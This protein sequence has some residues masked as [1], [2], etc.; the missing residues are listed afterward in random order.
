LSKRST[1]VLSF[2][3]R[4]AI[5]ICKVSNITARC[6]V[7]IYPFTNRVKNN[8]QPRA[9]YYV[10]VGTV[11]AVAPQEMLH[12]GICEAYDKGLTHMLIQRDVVLVNESVAPASMEAWPALARTAAKT[13]LVNPQLKEELFGPFSLLVECDDKAELLAGVKSLHGQLPR[14]LSVLL[15]TSGME[16]RY[17]SA[18]YPDRPCYF[19][20]P[21]HRRGGVCCHSTWRTIPGY[22]RPAFHF[23]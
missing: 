1:D 7:Y 4:Y 13:L 16:R 14:P 5:L 12:K 19:K 2:L 22:Y 6:I 23:R 3:T 8:K 15:Q 9:L 10:H 18:N 11:A 20:Q 17:Y 21:A